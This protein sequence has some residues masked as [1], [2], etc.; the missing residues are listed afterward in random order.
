MIIRKPYAFLIKHFRKIHIF[1]FLL[2]TY[3][4]YKTTKLYSFVKEFVVLGTYDSYSEPISGY[5]PFISYLFLILIIGALITIL[6]VLRKKNKP[7]KIYILPVVSYSCLFFIFIFT[8][9]FFASYDGSIS[10]T[11]ARA[12]RDILLILTVPQYLNFIILLI[13]ILGLDLNKFDF[14]TDEEFLELSESDRDEVEININIDKASFKRFIRRIKRNFTYYYKEHKKVIY[15]LIIILTIFV[16]Y[17]SYVYVFVTNKSY[18][19]GDVVNTNS[20][21]LTINHSYYSG[22]DYKGTTISKTSS[23]VILDV[24]IKNN[25]QSRKINFDRFHIMNGTSNYAPTAK[26][27]ATQFKDLGTPSE[28]K[29]IRSGEE[30]NTL[31]IYKVNGEE[32]IKHFV[33]YYQEFTG[34]NTSHLR[35][36]KLKLQNLSE[37]TENAQLNLG[38]TLNFNIGP[39]TQEIIFDDYEITDQ[40]SYNKELCNSSYCYYET[41]EQTA[42]EGYKILKLDFASNDFNGKDMI[43]FLTMYGKINYIDSE[44]KNHGIKIENALPTLQYYGKYAYIKVPSQITES[45]SIELIITVRNNQ[46]KYKLK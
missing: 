45:E 18:T 24:T 39:N 38:D 13:R 4:L 37:L 21:E 44:N 7:W 27:Y 23:F 10:T 16:G 43:D 14:K 34:N 19:Q 8:S 1:I 33:L 32:D 41:Y 5:I 29:T 35:K 25:A 2:C 11:T 30:F 26:T 31:L 15:T 20:Y 46:Y 40:A 36:I 17:K 3:I 12:I 22:L 9:G 42:Q 6:I 28:E